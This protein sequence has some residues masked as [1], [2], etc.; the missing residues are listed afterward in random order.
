MAS[1]FFSVMLLFATFFAF[2]KSTVVRGEPQ[3]SE[4]KFADK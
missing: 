2:K 1:L 4:N 3:T